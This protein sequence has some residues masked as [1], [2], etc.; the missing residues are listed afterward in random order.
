MSTMRC[1]ACGEMG[2]YAGMSQEEE[3]TGWVSN[4]SRG[5]RVQ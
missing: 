5:D 3:A 4:D 1:F 2:H